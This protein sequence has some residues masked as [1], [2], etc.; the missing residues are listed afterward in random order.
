MH[1]MSHSGPLLWKKL[2]Q[3]K[4]FLLSNA[5]FF[6]FTTP[7]TNHVLLLPS[8]SNIKNFKHKLT[9]LNLGYILRTSL[10][11][12]IQ[13]MGSQR[14]R[15]DWATKHSTLYRKVTPSHSTRW[16]VCGPFLQKAHP[17]DPTWAFVSCPKFWHKAHC[18]VFCNW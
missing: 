11:V 10:L 14:V 1:S 4:I 3:S 17:I 7:S 16:P 2:Y 13:S 5:F 18:W 8:G 9:F 12:S 15:H 6:Y